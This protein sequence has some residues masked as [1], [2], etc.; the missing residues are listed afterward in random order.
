[1]NKT[2]AEPRRSSATKGGR[3]GVRLT[4]EGYGMTCTT[5]KAS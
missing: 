1:M 5:P 3:G 4:Y 2:T